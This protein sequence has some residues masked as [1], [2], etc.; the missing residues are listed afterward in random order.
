MC[1]VK[2]FHSEDIKQSDKEKY[3]GDF[4]T[5]NSKDTISDRKIRNKGN[6]YG[7]PTWKYKKPNRYIIASSLLNG[8]VVNSEV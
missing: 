2:K 8:C 3:L 4:V 7:C 1:L 5:K 6:I